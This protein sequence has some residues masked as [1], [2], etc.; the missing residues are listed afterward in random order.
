MDHIFH[1]E[2]EEPNLTKVQVIK[3]LC[4]TVIII[5]KLAGIHTISFKGIEKQIRLIYQYVRNFKCLTPSARPGWKLPKAGELFDIGSCICLRGEGHRWCLT[6][7]SCHCKAGLSNNLIRF[8]HNQRDQRL[9][10]VWDINN[11]SV[12]EN[13]SNSQSIIGENGDEEDG[14]PDDGSLINVDMENNGNDDDN[15]DNNEWH[16]AMEQQ[17]KLSCDPMLNMD[18]TND[19]VS[20]RTFS[21][22]FFTDSESENDD[23]PDFHSMEDIDEEKYIHN[24]KDYPNVAIVVSRYGVSNRAAA[25]I[26]NA[27]LKDLEILCSSSALDAKKIIRCKVRA[28]KRLNECVRKLFHGKLVAIGFDER[29]D[30]TK[31]RQIKESL[32]LTDERNPISVTTSCQV[33]RK[34]E[35]CPVLAYG[36][37]SSSSSG[38]YI[39]HLAPEE[40]NAECLA[41][42]LYGVIQSFG[43]T[44]TIKAVCCD[45]CAKVGSM[46]KNLHINISYFLSP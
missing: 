20:D 39:T 9:F 26:C 10:S 15:E 7:L 21:R 40:K 34:E 46:S 43:S 18:N 14:N 45:G 28:G 36:G 17:P 12:G 22:G 6:V 35:H 19:M 8:Y 25:A 16:D 30:T 23:D 4:H 33:S 37:D 11:N 41:N 32:V 3:H 13:D 31:S 38:S 27:L 29:D 44:D 42:K 1:L 24:I 5:W 2:Y